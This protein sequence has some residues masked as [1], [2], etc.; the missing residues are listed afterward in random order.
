M[1][2]RQCPSIEAISGPMHPGYGSHTLTNILCCQSHQPGYVCVNI[3]MCVHVC[4]S[5]CLH[6]FCILLLAAITFFI[7]FY[8]TNITYS[9]YT[10]TNI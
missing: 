6:F 9:T 10:I 2:L 4:T 1:A 5:I 8:K 7:L 3:Q